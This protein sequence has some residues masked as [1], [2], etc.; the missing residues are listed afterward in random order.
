M[1]REI[2][3]TPRYRYVHQRVKDFVQEMKINS[4]PVDPIKLIEINKWTLRTFQFYA[5]KHGVSL[6][7]V[8]EAY[9][10]EDAFTVYCNGNYSIAYNDRI[11]SIGRI[12]FSLMHEIGHIYLRHLEEFNKTI[13]S[14][15]GLTK[16]EYKALESEADTFAAEVLAPYEVMLALEWSNYKIIQKMCGLSVQAA[17]IR[18]SQIFNLR[19]NG[20][21][22]DYDSPIIKYFYNFIFKRYCTSCSY[23]FVSNSAKYC[24]I[25][26]NKL[27]WGEG[28]MIY[29]DGYILDENGKAKICPRCE[30]EEPELGDYCSICGAYLINECTDV[31][32]IDFNGNEF[33]EKQGCHSIASGNA[34][35]CTI[36]GNPTT[37]YRAGFLLP[38]EE[39]KEMIELSDGFD[40]T[41]SEEAAAAEDD[42]EVPF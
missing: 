10:T 23:Y 35:Y 29:D 12:R 41:A 7:D 2:I 8:I 24:P 13:L 21:L 22:W 11:R 32:G 9:G 30:N 38:W 15:G 28:T 17:Q 25:C 18:A 1:T 16:Q 20:A 31:I 19:L 5:Q 26:G 33:I 40:T 42:N 4:L 14:R 27:K 36:C 39:A 37:F 3:R 6:K 34:R